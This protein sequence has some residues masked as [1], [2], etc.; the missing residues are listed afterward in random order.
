M[1]GSE[2][3]Y[4][5]YVPVH[6]RVNTCRADSSAHSV[7]ATVTHLD[8]FYLNTYARLQQLSLITNPYSI[9]HHVAEPIF[10]TS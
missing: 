3:K 2:L 10:G 5:L 7:H 8:V 9:L 6:S 1:H 4:V